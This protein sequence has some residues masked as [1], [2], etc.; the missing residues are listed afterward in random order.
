ME[1]AHG[2]GAAADGRHEDVRQ[3][4]LGL[5][6]LPAQL[7]ADDGLE[8][9]DHR[10]VRVRAGHGADAVVG[11]LHMRD[12]MTQGFVHRVL[13]RRRTRGDGHDLGA[14][15]LHAEHVGRL[16]GDV[17]RAHEDRAGQVEQRA[18]RRRRHAV[19]ARAGLGDHAPLAHAAGEQDLAEHGVDLVRAGVVELVALE[20]DF[21]A[22]QTFGETLREPQRA[23]AAHIVLQQPPPLVVEARV[24]PRRLVGAL[25]IEDEWHQRLGD[26]AAAEAAELA[27]GVG[28]GA[29]GV[30]RRCDLVHVAGVPEG[31]LARLGSVARARLKGRRGAGQFYSG[32]RNVMQPFTRGHAPR[33]TAEL[34]QCLMCSA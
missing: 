16:A 10:R 8:V 25:D 9:A 11:V 28:A 27:R 22:A 18:D 23:R 12:P 14:E 13:Q 15:Q 20:V 2:V 31:S 30:G 17:G 34:S 7:L 32:R 6:H 1:Q 26:V 29:V 3:P 4:A 5:G 19:L 24:A 21:R 33:A